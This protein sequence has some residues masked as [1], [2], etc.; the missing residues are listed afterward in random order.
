MTALD[1]PDYLRAEHDEWLEQ[2]LA[3]TE[4]GALDDDGRHDLPDLDELLAEPDPDYDF[5][6][7][8]LL[9]RGDRVI[10][11]GPEGG[12]KSTLLRQMLLQLACG[13]HPFTLARIEPV[14]VMLIDAENSRRQTR[15]KLR[16]LR[17]IAGDAYEPG[18]C[19]LHIVGHPLE[20]ARPEIYADV[21]AK[22]AQYRPQVIALGPLY[23]LGAADPTKEEPARDLAG[24]LDHLRAIS[25]A[26]LLIEAHTPYAESAKAKRPRRP[27]GA[28]LWSRWPEFGIYLSPEGDVEHWRG[29]RDERSWPTGLQRGGTWPWTV[30]TAAE[31]TEEWHGPTKCMEAVEHFLADHPDEE[32]SKTQMPIRLRAAGVS[33]RDAVVATALEKLATEGRISYRLGPRNS[34]LYRAPGT[35]EEQVIPLDL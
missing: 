25:G 8:G 20:L 31:P 9:E 32:I 21:A 34:H 13:L 33:Y 26:A 2:V 18:M 11:T 23:K 29:Q 35:E 14:A 1:E 3:D 30:R 16:D 10:F 19:R 6:V 17:D 5:V 7:D 15:R 24:A 27:Y 22:V 28:S 4:H 12:G